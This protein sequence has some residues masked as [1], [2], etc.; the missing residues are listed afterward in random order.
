MKKAT[1]KKQVQKF[2]LLTNPSTHV[3]LQYGVSL[4][5]RQLNLQFFYS[6]LRSQFVLVF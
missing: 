2:Q 4:L 1:K 5:Q 6:K 3:D